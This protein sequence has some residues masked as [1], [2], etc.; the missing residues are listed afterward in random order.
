[1]IRRICYVNIAFVLGLFLSVGLADSG[2]GYIQKTQIG[3]IDWDVGIIEVKGVGSPSQKD[4]GKTTAANERILANARSIAQKNLNKLINGIYID[5]TRY[6]AGTTLTDEALGPQI[7]SMIQA[8]RE[9]EDRRRYL[10]DG[11]VE[12]FLQFSLFGG[13]AQ[14]ILPAEIR[15]IQPIKAV[16]P[17]TSPE[18][19]PASPIPPESDVFTGLIVDARGVSLSPAMAP[20]IFDDAGQEVYGASFVSREY[21]VQSGV[22]AYLV[23]LDNARTNRR[24]GPNP[25]VARGLRS[26]GKNRCDLVISNADAEKLRRSSEHLEFLK[27]ARVIVV[28]DPEKPQ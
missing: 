19:S 7:E 5:A 20:R 22:C 1:M 6:V 10:S 14:L 3:K 24:I 2:P 12:I 17:A 15:Q 27:Q 8:A 9:I 25:L 26:T 21:A 13:F 18:G 4:D 16:S 28:V 11:S 23:D